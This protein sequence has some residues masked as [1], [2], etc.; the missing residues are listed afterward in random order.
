MSVDEELLTQLEKFRHSRTLI[1]GIGNTLKGDD[2]AGPAVCAELKG[3]VAA[4]VIDAG[5]VPEN[6]I[7]PII[8]KAP[9]LLLVIDVIDF[10]A[11]PGTVRILTPQSL[12]SLS[13]STHTP[14]P[15]L[16]ID[17]IRREIPV[18]VFFLGIQP[19]PLVSPTGPA[20]AQLGRPLSPQVAQAVK[21]LADAL[22]LTFDQND[23]G[24]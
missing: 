18:D 17:I 19:A 14:S 5:T 24:T 1:L 20:Q 12:S 10:A 8:K 3:R 15:R 13:T 23:A 2:G 6:Y 22:A 9:E 4:E 16:F 11:S 21:S 7:G